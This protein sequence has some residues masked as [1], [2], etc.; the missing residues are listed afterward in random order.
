LIHLQAALADVEIASAVPSAKVCKALLRSF[1]NR[2]EACRDMAVSCLTQILHIDPDSTLSLLPYVMPVLVERM[3]CDEVSSCHHSL[4]TVL[5][6]CCAQVLLS[7][8]VSSVGTAFVRHSAMAIVDI[9]YL[10]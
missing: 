3:Q 1:D 10:Q 2:T 8:A 4:H 5:K 6:Y 7:G 9:G